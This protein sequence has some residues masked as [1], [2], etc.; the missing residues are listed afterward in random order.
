VVVVLLL[1]LG[2]GCVRAGFDAP[3]AELG[4]GG[5]A[6]RE[7]GALD[8][9][10]D[11]LDLAADALDLAADAPSRPC[12]EQTDASTV[13]LYTFS[14]SGKTVTDATGKHH[15]TIVGTAVSRVSSRAGCGQ[16]IAFS[17][18]TGYVEI[19]DASAWDLATGS[20]DF[21]LRIDAMPTGGDKAGIISRDALNK[22]LSGHFTLYVTCNGALGARLQ[23]TVASG[24]ACTPVLKTKVWHHVGVNFGGGPLEIYVDGYMPPSTA[25]ISCNKLDFECGTGTTAGI[26][27][28]NNP[29]TVGVAS[30]ASK[31]DQAT[32][33]NDPLTGTIDSL[34][35]SSARR[36]FGAGK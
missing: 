36:A 26:D 32:P 13:A 9:A 1:L 22:A 31:E 7:G 14:G 23:T 35:I 24:F 8:L 4:T 21:W 27:G 28:N 29:W 11:A 20:I 3:S 15:G 30:A 10:A 16:A 2:G 18:A 12:V 6:A 33:T 19:P 25:T 34:R 17:G 5:D